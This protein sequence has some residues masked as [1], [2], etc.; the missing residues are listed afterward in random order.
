MEEEIFKVPFT[1]QFNSEV[2]DGKYYRIGTD[3]QLNDA[4]YR[5]QTNWELDDLNLD[6]K[7]ELV[8]QNSLLANYHSYGRKSDK[9]INSILDYC[10]IDG[11]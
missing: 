4:I 9:F 6:E 8:K 10:K 2:R 7:L 11:E 1:L 3:H 5:K